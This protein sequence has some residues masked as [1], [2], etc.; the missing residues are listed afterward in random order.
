MVGVQELEGFV[1]E[2][3]L[4]VI[5]FGCVGVSSVSGDS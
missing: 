2:L 3:D 1:F 4:R 5:E